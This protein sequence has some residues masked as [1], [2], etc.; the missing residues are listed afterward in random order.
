[1]DK[2]LFEDYSELIAPI[3]KIVREYLTISQGY[4]K[5]INYGG[6][7]LYG[8]VKYTSPDIKEQLNK[9]GIKYNKGQNRD[10]I[11]ILIHSIFLLGFSS[12]EYSYDND[13]TGKSYVKMLELVNNHY[14]VENDKLKKEIKNL[15]EQLNKNVW[16]NKTW[17]FSN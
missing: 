12:K 13:L 1:M 10:L 17:N 6:Q 9:S 16:K 11:D 3:T 2:N 4:S 15:K 8:S 5:G 14:E 7:E